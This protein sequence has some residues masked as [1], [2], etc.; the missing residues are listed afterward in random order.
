MRFTRLSR[1]RPPRIQPVDSRR[2]TRVDL[3][4]AA[5]LE[6]LT[7]WNENARPFT[8]VEDA[9]QIIGATGRYCP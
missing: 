8:W 7:H 1:R 3:P 2:M 6:W 5:L 4:G 9:D